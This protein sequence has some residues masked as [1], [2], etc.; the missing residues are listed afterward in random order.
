MVQ[1]ERETPGLLENEMYY[2]SVVE[3]R[4]KMCEDQT[5][6]HIIGVKGAS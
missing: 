2:Q 1:S 4:T 3:I 5:T 6:G